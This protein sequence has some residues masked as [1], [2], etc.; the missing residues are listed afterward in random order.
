MNP[1]MTTCAQYPQISNVI[2]LVRR[3][4]VMNI[5]LFL[6]CFADKAFVSILL[7][8]PFS[9]KT[10]AFSEIWIL[11]IRSLEGMKSNLL[12]F[13]R[14]KFS[15]FSSLFNNLFAANLTTYLNFSKRMLTIFNKTFSRTKRNSLVFTTSYIRRSFKEMLFTFFTNQFNFLISRF[16]VT[17]TATK[18][19]SPLLKFLVTCQTALH[20]LILTIS[21]VKV[22]EKPQEVPRG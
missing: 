20:T 9:I 22:N 21:T 8:G 6:S 1:N 10:R 14:A 11:F 2:Y 3:I 5:K 4:Y 12:A 7:K 18:L 15:V 16:I 19:I 13:I 17:S